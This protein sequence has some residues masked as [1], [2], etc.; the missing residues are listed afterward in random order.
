MPTDIK[1]AFK[2]IKFSLRSTKH[3]AMKTYWGSGGTAPRI[4]DLGTRWRW[5]VSFTTRPLYPQ[6]KTPWYPF[7]RRLGGPRSRSGRGGEEKN[8]QPRRESNRRT[9]IVQP[10]AQSLY[11]LS[12]HGS[13]FKYMWSGKDN[14][15]LLREEKNK[16]TTTECCNVTKCN[17]QNY[18]VWTKLTKAFHS[19]IRT[20]ILHF[21]TKITFIKVSYFFQR[22]VIII[23]F[24]TLD[25]MV[26][27]LLLLD[28]F[29]L[30][31]CWYCWW[32]RDHCQHGDV[33]NGT[34]VIVL[35]SVET[36]Q[37]VSIILMFIFKSE[38]RQTDRQT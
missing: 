23:H 32:Q 29:A 12:Y 26:L 14:A 37:L 20:V 7:N 33:S 34:T 31:P 1:T 30:P 36:G 38:D 27:V 8:T 9:P 16:S 5:V 4:L 13:S 10:L 18:K 17:H 6:G 21:T 11:R 2:C 35:T 19:A 24:E 28:K 3:N 15:P 25:W 22:Y